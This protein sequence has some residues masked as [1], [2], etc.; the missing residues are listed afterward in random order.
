MQGNAQRFGSPAAGT[1]ETRWLE[2]TFSA[3]W[4]PHSS[5]EGGQVEPLLAG[6]LV[7]LQFNRSIIYRRNRYL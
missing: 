2:I 1:G 5:A 3:K 7:L 6:L 4:P